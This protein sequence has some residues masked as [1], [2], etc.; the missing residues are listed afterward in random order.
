MPPK[1]MG[2]RQLEAAAAAAASIGG[3]SSVAPGT[4][5]GGGTKGALKFTNFQV[6]NIT[7]WEIRISK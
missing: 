6:S 7:N 2:S 5:T 4:G 1:G 3:P